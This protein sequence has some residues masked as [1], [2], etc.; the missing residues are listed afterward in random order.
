MTGS[1]KSTSAFNTNKK[2]H[3]NTYLQPKNLM[4][5]FYQ[6]L[7][8][9]SPLVRESAVLC[10]KN[11]GAHGEL[12]F[13]EGVSKEP[14]AQVRAECAYGLGSIGVQTFRSLLLALHDSF[15]IVKD[16]AS[17]AILN[18]MPFH[19]LISHFEDKDHQKQTIC[20]TIKELLVNNNINSQ[21]YLR[22]DIIQYLRHLLGTFDNTT[23]MSSFNQTVNQSQIQNN[24]E[25]QN[26]SYQVRYDHLRDH[27]LGP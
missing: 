3:F 15:Q 18:H 13:I 14:N 19:Q 12:L 21:S 8:D 10:I 2:A 9:K 7:R 1:H 16:A 22:Q 27:R 25:N 5:F 4:P 26:P 23:M 20:C 11:F 6:C 17:L 24:F